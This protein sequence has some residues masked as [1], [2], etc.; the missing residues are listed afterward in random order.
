MGSLR[1]LSSGVLD[2]PLVLCDCPVAHSVLAAIAA[3]SLLLCVAMSLLS[4]CRVA[5]RASAA[6]VR[7]SPSCAVAALSSAPAAPLSRCFAAQPAA[8]AA[9]S[10]LRS[11]L[12][13]S[14]APRR[15]LHS[16]SLALGGGGH[17]AAHGSGFHGTDF[18]S[19]DNVERRV[20]MILN[21]VEKIDKTKLQDPNRSERD[22][23]DGTG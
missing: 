15:S 4:V 22:A 6:P 10:S 1:P 17:D 16:A 7:R 21:E 18:L 12:P 13:L 5:L 8:A 20:M 3:S 23:H 11:A 19:R 9:S 14:F 2:A